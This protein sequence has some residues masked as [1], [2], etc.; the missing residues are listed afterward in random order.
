MLDAVTLAGGDVD[1]GVGSLVA[2]GSAVPHATSTSASN[3]K[4]PSRFE[5]MDFVRPTKS[6][7]A[8]ARADATLRIEPIGNAQLRRDV[9][10]PFQHLRVVRDAV[11]S[12][13]DLGLVLG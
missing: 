13:V 3:T 1:E 8:K 7:T 11:G 10:K 2:V 6:W 5:L 9:P 4:A 12:T